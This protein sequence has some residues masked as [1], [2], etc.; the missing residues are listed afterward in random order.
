MQRQFAPPAPAF[1][2]ATVLSTPR[3]NE[4]FQPLPPPTGT[5]PFR[6]RLEEILGEDGVARIREAGQ[7]TFH[8]AGDTGGVKD[9]KPQQVVAMKME[10]D[11]KASAGTA[12]DP[13]FFY[14]VGDVVYFNGEAAN[15]FDQFYYPYGHYDRP[16]VAVPGNHDG[17][18][19]RGSTASLDAF[20]RNFCAPHPQVTADAGDTA[21]T[22]MTQPN[23]YWTLE[24][25]FATLVGLYTNVPEGGEV[26]ADQEEWLIGELRDAPNDRALLVTLHHPPYSVDDHHSG[27]AGMLE[28]LE[29]AGERAGRFPDAVFSGHVHN[30]Q[31]F[32]RTRS[33]RQVPFIVCGNGG[34]W[35]L[36][37]VGKQPDGTPLPVPFD[38]GN[39]LVLASYVDDYHG[40]LKVTVSAH[41]LNG[42]F[43][44]APRPQDSFRDPAQVADRWTLDLQSHTV[45]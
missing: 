10:E 43:Y 30:Y 35:H 5:A 33:E 9:P 17:S 24:T 42:T 12:E 22:A 45:S 21:R 7:L 15:Y 4:R 36:H 14:H 32:T 8:L 19:G 28:L 38:L 3:P 31:R 44:S 13:S 34:Y 16:I 6:L 20:V 23:V 26:H 41:Q 25:P 1:L 27:S 37:Y 40:F 2:E 18:V 39:G 11:L 29:R